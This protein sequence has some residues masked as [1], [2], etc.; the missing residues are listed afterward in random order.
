M[1]HYY[2]RE[3]EIIGSKGM[4]RISFTPLEQCSHYTGKISLMP[5]YDAC[6]NLGEYNFDYYDKI[7]Y[8]GGPGVVRHF[9]D[10]MNGKASPI[11]TVEQAFA[12]EVIGYVSNLASRKGE[13]VRVEE[14]IPADLKSVWAGI[15]L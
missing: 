9:V 12:A 15:K 1:N 14:A 7:H 4:L 8:N 11:T 10:L 2:S 13:F 6:G 3:Y 5:R